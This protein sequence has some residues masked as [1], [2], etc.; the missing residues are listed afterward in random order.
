MNFR[1]LICKS[2]LPL[3]NYSY[4]ELSGLDRDAYIKKFAHI[5]FLKNFTS[6]EACRQLE[7][8]KDKWTEI[9]AEKIIY[10]SEV[11]SFDVF[12]DDD[13]SVDCNFDI[14]SDGFSKFGE[15]KLKSFHE[16]KVARCKL[17]KLENGDYKISEYEK[18]DEKPLSPLPMARYIREI[19]RL[20]LSM[21]VKNE[22]DRYLR[23]VLESARDYIDNAVI[24]DDGSTDDTVAICEEV[25]ADIP[26]K[27]V[28]NSGS[29]FS[30]SEV[31]L[32]EKQWNEVVATDPDWILFLDSD[33]IFEKS[34]EDEVY[35]LMSND[36]VDGYGFRLYDFW[37]ENHY[38]DD[39][40]WCAHQYYKLFMLRYQPDFDYKFDNTAH[41]CPRLPINSNALCT[42]SSQ[43][44]LKHFGWAKEEDR[45]QKYERYMKMDPL[46]I[47][48][49]LKQYIS[50]MDKNINL[51]EWSE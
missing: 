26:L 50:I 30:T 12:E 51:V 36:L 5:D 40:L 4:R 17:T 3:E 41:H 33:E 10:K 7:I 22:A 19:P 23:P 38:R 39:A 20:S 42:A 45:I 25:L 21:V 2:I 37:D 32:R 44:R 9:I 46:G 11:T 16:I 28:K 43:L 47:Y 27:I 6:D 8:F 49:S 29:D 48:N 34:F 18:I 31:N 1:D 14:L 15:D 13:S 35:Y 24:I